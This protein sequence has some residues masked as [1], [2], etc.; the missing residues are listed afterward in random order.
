MI[1]TTD[2]YKEYTEK[3]G[4]YG[5]HVCLTD[6]N[7]D[8]IYYEAQD[9]G[10]EEIWF[11]EE[12]EWDGSHIKQGTLRITDEI[13][14]PGTLGLGAT[15]ANTFSC[16]LFDHYP[17]IYKYRGN[18][19]QFIISVFGTYDDVFYNERFQRG[20]YQI[21]V[22]RESDGTARLVGNDKMGSDYFNT[23]LTGTYGTSTTTAYQALQAI[24][25]TLNQT[26]FPNST[27]VVGQ[28]SFTDEYG[29]KNA[30]RRDVLGLICEMCGCYARF[31][32]TGNLV[33]SRIRGTNTP[34]SADY[35]V[36]ALTDSPSVDPVGKYI[37]GIIVKAMDG[38]VAKKEVSDTSLI[39]NGCYLTLEG[40]PF[41]KTTAQAQDCA[42]TLYS[43]YGMFLYRSANLSVLGD[44]S[45][46]AGDVISVEID[47]QQYA[48]TVTSMDYTLNGSCTLTASDAP[49]DQT[50][51]SFL[52][53]SANQYGYNSGDTLTGNFI[54]FGSTVNSAEVFVEIPISKPINASSVAITSASGNITI[55]G[56]SGF[57][58]NYN[59]ASLD[60]I[61]TQINSG[62]IR[63]R[64]GS[65]TTNYV[66]NSPVTFNAT[67][68]LSFT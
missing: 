24:G 53:K 68:T 13:C 2:A 3:H 60:I 33:I 40:N 45:W 47:G 4:V 44:P 65:L 48:I 36:S 37:I 18:Y 15:I 5:V 58:Y 62:G 32:A 50:E 41:I 66:A 57:L 20:F 49:E 59:L 1:P 11:E 6:E 61:N 42:N 12:I 28:F 43:M 56:V 23:A 35:E 17:D 9:P 30:T 14:N 31:D 67:L 21:D 52:A 8:P 54:G 25:I 10:G 26:S 39:T 7:G 27:T 19:V 51:D 22:A 64:I 16:V 46:E 34:S 63:L 38:S 55:R 29:L